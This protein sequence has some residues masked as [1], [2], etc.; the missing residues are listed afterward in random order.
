MIASRQK[1]TVKTPRQHR[2]RKA[3]Q[4]P[5][6]FML[7]PYTSTS[8]RKCSEEYLTHLER[9]VHGCVFFDWFSPRAWQYRVIQVLESQNCSFVN[10]N[11][12]YI[13]WTFLFQIDDIKLMKNHETGR[14]QGYG[15]IT[16]SVHT[17]SS[18][19]SVPFRLQCLSDD[20]V[21]GI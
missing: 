8:P 12:P 9:C 3:L 11:T 14:S 6:G 1:R 18:L 15:F 17:V 20:L 21:Y 4:V 16:V 7:A 19:L 13:N 5:W 2:L 10:H